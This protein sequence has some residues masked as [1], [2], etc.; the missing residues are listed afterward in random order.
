MQTEF[1][2][3]LT[4]Q[5]FAYVASQLARAAAGRT[6]SGQYEQILGEAE[7]HRSVLRLMRR[8]MLEVAE[9]SLRRQSL[10]K[11]DCQRLR[12]LAARAIAEAEQAID[13]IVAQYAPHRMAA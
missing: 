3:D 6:P 7:K 2:A 12:E 11:S 9:Q 8:D 1:A 13:T 4:V 5:S 10:S